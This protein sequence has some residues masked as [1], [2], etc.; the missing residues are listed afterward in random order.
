MI[1]NKFLI[2]KIWDLPGGLLIDFMRLSRPC[3]GLS[4]SEAGDYLA[5]CHQGERGVFLWANKQ[6][7]LAGIPKSNVA[8]ELRVINLSFVHYNFNYPS[9]IVPNHPLCLTQNFVNFLQFQPRTTIVTLRRLTW[10]IKRMNAIQMKRQQQATK[11]IQMMLRW[12]TGHIPTVEVLLLWK[13]LIR[14]IWL[15]KQLEL[16]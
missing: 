13:T 7:F 12:L 14:R 3:V 1:L 2:N 8:K 4:F 6:L 15:K 10:R 5:T 16:L 11:T 9:V